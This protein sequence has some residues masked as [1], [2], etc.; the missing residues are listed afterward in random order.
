L[1]QDQYP[2]IG[3][4]LRHGL[5]GTVKTTTW[6]FIVLQDLMQVIALFAAQIQ[7]AL[8]SSDT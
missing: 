7:C 2:G 4:C 8:H 1:S 6:S 3:W 5:T